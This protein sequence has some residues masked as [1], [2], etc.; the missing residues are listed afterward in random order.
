MSF[1]LSHI[2][3]FVKAGE[4]F[5][6]IS[7]PVMDDHPRSFHFFSVLE[8][9]QFTDENGAQLRIQPFQEYSEALPQQE[10]TKAEH[11]L[12]VSDAVSEIHQHKLD[13]V[14]VSRLIRSPRHQDQGLSHILQKLGTM[15]PHS[16]VFI[17][18]HDQYGAWM[19]ATPELLFTKKENKYNTISLAGTQPFQ[20]DGEYSWSPKL[21]HEQEL[22]TDFIVKEIERLNVKEISLDGPKVYLA[23]PVVHLK[24]DVAFKS[25]ASAEQ[26]AAALHPTP[27]VC[28]LPRKSAIDFILSHERHQRRLYTGLFGIDHPNG[29]ADYYVGL[30]CM[31]IFPDHFELFVGGGITSESIPDDEW[32]ETEHKSQVLLHAIRTVDAQK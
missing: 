19:G 21:R 25:G 15:Y 31:Q 4:P 11:A 9:A 24:T 6:A 16:M 27:A 22:V 14:I 3:D 2:D 26:I 18:Q 17:I 8:N 30:R 1:N 29:D 5:A 23:G 32:L 28:G 13:K 20:A 12:M 7:L 10:T